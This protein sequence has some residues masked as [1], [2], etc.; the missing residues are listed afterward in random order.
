M[1]DIAVQLQKM[2]EG[3][4]E[5]ILLDSKSFD[6]VKAWYERFCSSAFQPE[7]AIELLYALFIRENLDFYVVDEFQRVSNEICNKYEINNQLFLHML[8]D[9]RK[10]V[11]EQ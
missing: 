8:S 1:T 2:R 7:R 3:I 5:D 4:K 9:F 11:F 10:I 6:V